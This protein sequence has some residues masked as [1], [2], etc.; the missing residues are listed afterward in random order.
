MIRLRT[1][2]FP[3]GT[4][5]KLHARRAG[6]FKIIKRVGPNAYVIELPPGLGISSTFNISDLV[7]YKEPA[8]ISSEPFGPIPS[9]ESEPAPE[10]PPTNWP[11][12]EEKIERILDDQAIC[13]RNRGYQR[14][15]VRWQGQ[16]E[17]EDSWITCEDLQCLNPD[18]LE[19]YESQVI[20]HSIGSSSSYTGR[21]GGG[22]RI[23][24]I[25]LGPIWFA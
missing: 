24:H 2:R 6:P 20:P 17:S 18:L 7:E 5:K 12:S 19:H 21:I 14:Y 9:F 10:C 13:T 15:L 8:V 22:T 1:E 11:N 4:I 25:L 23:R 16:P 3:P